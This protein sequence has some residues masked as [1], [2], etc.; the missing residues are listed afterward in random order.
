MRCQAGPSRLDLPTLITS[1]PWS[2]QEPGSGIGVLPG[3]P[4]SRRAVKA[5]GMWDFWLPPVLLS[6]AGTWAQLAQMGGEKSQCVCDELGGLGRT[7]HGLGQHFTGAGGA[8]GPWWPSH[9]DGSLSLQVGA[10]RAGI[11]GGSKA[12]SL[13]QGGWAAH[14]WPGQA[15]TL[16]L[17][18]AGAL[19]LLQALD[20]RHKW[21]LS[22]AC[23]PCPKP[24]SGSLEEPREHGAACA[25]W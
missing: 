21:C 6:G 12:G 22:Q 19:P 15:G 18:G 11:P 13:H 23:S 3:F 10:E 8:L 1:L 20:R 17:G 7:G 24:L 16:P 25:K 5:P 4:L 2:S 9:S 14:G